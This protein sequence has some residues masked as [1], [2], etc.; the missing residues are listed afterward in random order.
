MCTDEGFEPLVCVCLLGCA[1]L[2]HVEDVAGT[3]CD[4]VIGGETADNLNVVR[5]ADVPRRRVQSMTAV[6]R[7]VPGAREGGIGVPR[8]L[9]MNFKR[10]LAM[11]RACSGSDPRNAWCT[12]DT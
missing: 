3:A 7:D 1:L 11:H 8:F 9:Q 10:A 4:D 12:A 5:N 6:G 2:M